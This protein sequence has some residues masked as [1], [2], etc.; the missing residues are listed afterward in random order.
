MTT[1][2]LVLRITQFVYEEED[3]FFFL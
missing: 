3:Q 1:N 2:Y